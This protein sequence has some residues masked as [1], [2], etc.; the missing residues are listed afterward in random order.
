MRFH[1]TTATNLQGCSKFF[2]GFKG[3]SSTIQAPGEINFEE[4]EYSIGVRF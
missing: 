4:D 3:F 1:V 2:D